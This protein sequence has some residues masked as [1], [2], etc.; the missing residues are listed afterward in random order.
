MRY[1]YFISLAK[2]GE[3]GFEHEVT[4]LDPFRR[5]AADRQA[6]QQGLLDC[7]N[8]LSKPW[9]SINGGQYMWRQVLAILFLPSGIAV[10]LVRDV[11]STISRAAVASHLQRELDVARCVVVSDL[12]AGFDIPACHERVPFAPPCVGIA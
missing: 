1:T 12:I 3:K 2:K 5:C 11:L 8:A 10:V 9:Q 6:R 7:R 4:A